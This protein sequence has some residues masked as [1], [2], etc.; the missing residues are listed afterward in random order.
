MRAP[1]GPPGPLKWGKWLRPAGQERV[2]ALSRSVRSQGNGPV[3]KSALSRRP[4]YISGGGMASP[5]ANLST[6][7][8]RGH[9]ISACRMMRI[10]I[11][12]NS[13]ARNRSSKGI[14]GITSENPGIPASRFFFIVLGLT[15]MTKKS[16]DSRKTP[17]QKN[18]SVTRDSPA[19]K[20]VS[21]APLKF[22]EAVKGLAKMRPSRVNSPNK[23]K[24]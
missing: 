23:P 12:G 19:E 10:I 20:P 16:R 5:L 6:C 9:N 13:T 24:N 14:P 21:L 7:S 17:V 1:P 4:G 22:E 11:A 15:R 18:E 2:A 8:T 3:R